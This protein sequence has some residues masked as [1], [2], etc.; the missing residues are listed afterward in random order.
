MMQPKTIVAVA[1]NSAGIVLKQIE[2]AAMFVVK[3][4]DIKFE[5][6][7][8]HVEVPACSRPIPVFIGLINDYAGVEK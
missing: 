8:I 4:K 3:S 6:M 2:D 7:C 1:A 5:Y